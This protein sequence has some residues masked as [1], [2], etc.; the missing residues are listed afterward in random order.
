MDIGFTGTQKGMT[1]QQLEKV[2]L[3]VANIVADYGTKTTAHHG[4]CIGADAQ[5]HVVCYMHMLPIVGHPPIN[6]SKRMNPWGFTYEWEPKEYIPRNH[7]IV[8]CSDVLLATP[9]EYEE[10]LRSGTWA[11]IRFARKKN[12]PR[13]I[14]FPDGTI[15]ND[16]G[17]QNV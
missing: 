1:D 17:E 10:Q 16:E 11:T 7:D 8:L 3:L 5:F 14:I 4:E 9:A 13:R 15:S 12:V 6:Q 2:H